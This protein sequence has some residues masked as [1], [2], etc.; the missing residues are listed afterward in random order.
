MKMMH[1]NIFINSDDLDVA[2][3]FFEYFSA[4]RKL[5]AEDDTLFCVSAWND[6]G[7]ENVT[8]SLFYSIIE[9]QS[10]QC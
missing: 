10:N 2:A 7:K 1:S 8:D 6:N 5:L 4:T 3:D 9:F